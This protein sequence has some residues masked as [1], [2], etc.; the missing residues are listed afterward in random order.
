MKIFTGLFALLLLIACQREEPY[1]IP[2]YAW[3]SGP[4]QST[5]QELSAKCND[6]ELSNHKMNDKIK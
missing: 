5:N 1:K 2:V 6:F 3:T 4:G